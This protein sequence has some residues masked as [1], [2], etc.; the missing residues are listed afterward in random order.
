MNKKH[1]LIGLLCSTLLLLGM[2]LP[3]RMEAAPHALGGFSKQIHQ[4]SV[5]MRT[6]AGEKELVHQSFSELVLSQELQGYSPLLSKAV[7]NLNRKEQEQAK[8][9]RLSLEKDAK[10]FYANHPKDFRTFSYERDLQMCRADSLVVSFLQ[11]EYS[12]TGGVHGNYG[13][14]G[15]NL[16]TLTG[17][18]LAISDVFTDTETLSATIVTKLRKKYPNSAFTHLDEHIQ[19]LSADGSFNWTLDPRGATF[20][21]NPYEIAPYAEGILTVTIL[22]QEQPQLFQDSYRQTAPEYAEPFAA[23]NLPLV[24]SLKDNGQTDTISII[25]SREAMHIRVNGKESVFPVYAA[26]LD[27][28]LIHMADGRN[29][30]YIGGTTNDDKEQIFVFRLDGNTAHHIGTLPYTFRHVT[31]SGKQESYHFLTNPNGFLLDKN[32][33]D[34]SGIVGTDICS[35]GKDGLLAFG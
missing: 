34:T 27:P 1:C 25:T 29:Y 14:Y 12:Y 26:Y 30:L 18:P 21:F 20:Y 9:M 32:A 11:R 5:P 15:V 2:A 7:A 28:I 22:F 31:S 13:Q 10:E 23:N 17:A 33:P 35:V 3:C 16:N 4:K 24:T 6:P 8:E 19:S